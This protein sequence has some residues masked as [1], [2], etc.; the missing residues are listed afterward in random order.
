MANAAIQ[1]SDPHST[2]NKDVAGI[3]LV[4]DSHFATL[5]FDG[6]GCNR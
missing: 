3:H 6:M 5:L 1:P 2:D 4:A